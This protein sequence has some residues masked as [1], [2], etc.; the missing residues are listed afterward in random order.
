MWSKPIRP[1]RLMVGI[2]AHLR[3]RKHERAA[4]SRAWILSHGWR[5]FRERARRWLVWAISFVWVA[6]GLAYSPAAAR[7]RSRTRHHLMCMGR[8]QRGTATS[9]GSLV[10]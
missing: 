5:A 10:I 3:N 4:P 7:N 8:Q 2:A 9:H 6:H 1:P